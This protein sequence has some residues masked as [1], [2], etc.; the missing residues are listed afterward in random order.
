[1]KKYKG[2]F[3][4]IYKKW[5]LYLF[6]L[7]QLERHVENLKKF[8]RFDAPLIEDVLDPAGFF[9]GD[10]RIPPNPFIMNDDDEKVF[11]L[12]FD[13]LECRGDKDKHIDQLFHSIWDRIGHVKRFLGITRNT[14]FC[15]EEQAEKRLLNELDVFLQ[16][17]EA[18]PVIYSVIFGAVPDNDKDMDKYYA[19]ISAF[20]EFLKDRDPIGNGRVKSYANYWKK[21]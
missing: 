17:P 20:K 11:Y 5:E 9:E 16:Y 12:V 10:I 21:F 3:D 13:D 2:L 14:R 7:F 15:G 8:M 4:S 18:S 19:M 1:M 6:R